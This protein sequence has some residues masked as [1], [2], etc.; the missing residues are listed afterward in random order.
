MN[1]KRFFKKWKQVLIIIM[2]FTMIV[3]SVGCNKKRQYKVGILSGLDTL[4]KAVDG[5]KTKMTELGYT[6]GENITYD[7]QKTNSDFT[8]YKNFSKKFVD[9]KVDLI[10]CF[11][12]EAAL[13]LKEATKETSIPV[14][15]AVT[16][17]E[18]TDLVK[19]I[20]EPGGNITGVR[21]PGPDLTLKRFEIMR[22]IAPQ[23]NRILI[24]YKSDMPVCYPQLDA[25]RPVAQ[26]AGVILVE[27]PAKTPQELTEFLQIHDIEG[28]IGFDAI[29]LIAEAFGAMPNTFMLM[30]K[31]ADKHKIPIGG[32][33]MDVEGHTS[34]FGV[35]INPWV[36]GEK[37]AV[38]ADKILKGEKAATVSVV[39]DDNF[40]QINYKEAQKKGYTLS[41]ELLSQANEIIK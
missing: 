3:S 31:Y 18:D 14:V 35:N 37:A 22:Q 8:D 19:S 39:S 21:Y 10:F 7:L 4:G 16:N 25:L 40:V 24:P 5:F 26:Q 34:L 38:L 27:A 23:A 9:D 33:Y 36:T 28:D 1:S 2:L 30:S 17:I 13:E 11:P 20:R 15:F 29:L 12:T 6:E 41:E 32:R